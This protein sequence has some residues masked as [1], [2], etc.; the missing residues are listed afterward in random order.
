MSSA[1]CDIEGVCTEKE[2]G[3]HRLHG[4]AV[5]GDDDRWL[6]SACKACNTAVGDPSRVNYNPPALHLVMRI[7]CSEFRS[8]GERPPNRGVNLPP[9]GCRSEKPIL[10]RYPSGVSSRTRRF[11]VTTQPRRDSSREGA[12]ATA[13]PGSRHPDR[14]KAAK[15]PVQSGSRS[16]HARGVF[17]GYART[18]A[19][20]RPWNPTAVARLRCGQPRHRD[21]RERQPAVRRAGQGPG[22][23]RS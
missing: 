3:V 15:A 17:P 10:L 1:P 7:E 16:S 21:R 18:I 20:L 11:D 6:A 13:G 19:G 9:Q 14:R 2:R 4:R 12:R 8:K 22:G 5:A 23:P